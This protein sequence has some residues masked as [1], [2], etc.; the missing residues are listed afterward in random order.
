MADVEHGPIGT[1]KGFSFTRTPRAGVLVR[2]KV[3]DRE[4]DSTMSTTPPIPVY[5]EVELTAAEWIDVVLAVSSWGG[6]Q[7]AGELRERA[8]SVAVEM[9]MGPPEEA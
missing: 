1:R 7:L 5:R 8:L 2:V 4:P 9:H 6:D 3:G